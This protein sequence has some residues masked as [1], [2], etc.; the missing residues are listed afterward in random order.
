MPKNP[1]LAVR[2]AWHLA[3]AE[4]L[5]AVAVAGVGSLDVRVHGP[6]VVF[7]ERRGA[8][9]AEDLPGE[10]PRVAVRRDLGRRLDPVEHRLQALL[11]LRLR[12]L[13]VH[14]R[15]RGLDLDHRFDEAPAE[16]ENALLFLVHGMPPSDTPSGAPADK[17]L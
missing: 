3:H 6:R 2:L 13:L 1:S 15:D 16:P 11:P 12:H 9:L 4:S 7:V 5:P 17:G 14:R 10:L 8:Q